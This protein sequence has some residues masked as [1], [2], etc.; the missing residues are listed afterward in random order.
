[1]IEVLQQRQ[2]HQIWLDSRTHTRQITNSKTSVLPAVKAL[3]PLF[4]LGSR[5]HTRQIKN[6]ET[7]LLPAVKA[8]GPLFKL[9]EVHL[10]DHG[11]S[12]GQDSCNFQQRTQTYSSRQDRPGEKW[13]HSGYMEYQRR[14]CASNN[15]L[16][17]SP[18]DVK[19]AKKMND[20]PRAS[21]TNK[22]G[23]NFYT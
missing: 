8:L 14:K 19:V 20:L 22:E 15:G 9:S 23:R 13:G 5:S 1:M 10:W 18:E 3:G 16:S 21:N 6:S 7:S 17:S 12:G 2:S 4:E 11:P